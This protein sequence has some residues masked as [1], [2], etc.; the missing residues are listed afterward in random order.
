MVTIRKLK[1]GDIFRVVAM[2]RKVGGQAAELTRLISSAKKNKKQNNAVAVSDDDSD[3]TEMFVAVG[4]KVLMA[5][6][7]AVSDDFINWMADLAGMSRA[8]FNEA[9]PST[10]LE[11]IDQLVH[12]ED[13]R[14]FFTTAWQL[15]NRIKLSGSIIKK[16]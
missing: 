4:T 8:D 10:T 14:N 15:F 12:G 7:D 11:I 9:P 13:A 16:A 5:C 6:Y 1:N 2:L 3:T